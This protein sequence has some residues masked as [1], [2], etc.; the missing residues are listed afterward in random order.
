MHLALDDGFRLYYEVHGPPIGAAGVAT[1]VVL[2]HGAGGNAMSWWQQVPALADRYPVITFDHRAFGRSQD[3]EDGPGRIAFGSDLRQLL[4][5][6]GV[7][8]VHFVGHSMGGRTAFG[9]LSRDPD[10]VVS[11]TYSGTNGGCLDDRYRDL[12]T[13]LESEGVLAGSLI[14]R[15]L[16]DSFP[17]ESPEM[18]YLYG[19]I[20][21]INPSRSSD[22]L[23]PTGRMVNYRGSTAQRL[24]DSGLPILWLV[25]EH[26]RVVH[27]D[28]I[29]I[30]HELTPGSRFHVVRGAG[31]S[32]YFERPDE[33][34]R[35][36]RGFLDEVED[37]RRD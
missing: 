26:D 15:A 32:A 1:P 3:L 19:R 34:N 4:D 21:G 27:R 29:A 23:K 17:A 24:V 12:K 22:F 7:G 35:T 8:R 30:S 16:A 10:R 20:R 37:G 18:H 5:H 9:L 2:A 14:Q 6:L 11:L 13:R 28:L 25:G 33:W 31:H 36:V